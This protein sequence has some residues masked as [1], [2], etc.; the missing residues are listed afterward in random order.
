MN[1][2][3]CEQRIIVAHTHTHK[4]NE[5]MHLLHSTPK[6][7]RNTRKLTLSYRLFC[8]TPNRTGS[9]TGP[10]SSRRLSCL[11]LLFVRFGYLA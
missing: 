3:F 8:A 1:N 2:Y 11:C 6:C 7:R 5:T 10:T 4:Q 9:R